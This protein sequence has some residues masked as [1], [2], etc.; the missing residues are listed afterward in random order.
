MTP[1]SMT[2][3]PALRPGCRLS[4]ASNPESLL[5]IP[6][7]ALRLQ[8]PGRQILELCD[9]RRTLAEIVEELYRLFPSADASLIAGEAVSF[10]ERLHAKGT[11]EFL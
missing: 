2:N 11:V 6:E 9:G 5:L 8:G 3:R 1:P 4:P 10:L 7:G